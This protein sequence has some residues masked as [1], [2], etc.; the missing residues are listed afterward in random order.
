LEFTETDEPGVYELIV[1]P[2]VNDAS[3]KTNEGIAKGGKDAS[4]RRFVANL[5][6]Y[7]SDLT[8]LDEVFA[9][10]E[11]DTKAAGDQESIEAG[12][13][14]LLGGSPLVAYVADPQ[15]VHEAS[16]SAR[17]GLKLWDLVLFIALIVALVEPWLANRIS[18]RHYGRPKEI[19][20]PRPIGPAPMS[21]SAAVGLVGQTSN[22]G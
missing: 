11:S 18:L 17:R 14:E 1:N 15:R 20:A 6:S 8:Y 5:E 3:H 22:V 12:F 2:R 16:L 10:S 13:R 7:E 21:R 19:V 9:R 4:G